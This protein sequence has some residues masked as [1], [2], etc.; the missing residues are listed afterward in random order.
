[1][2]TWLGVNPDGKFVVFA[3]Q[4]DWYKPKRCKIPIEK[5]T[6]EWEEDYHGHMHHVWKPTGE[7]KEFWGIDKGAGELIQYYKGTEINPTSLATHLQDR[8]WEDDIITI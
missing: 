3:Y 8:T 4:Y 1:M 5:E 6:E 2:A 7:Y